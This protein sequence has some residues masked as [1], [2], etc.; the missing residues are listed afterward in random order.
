MCH[1]KKAL[2]GLIQAPRAWFLWLL[3][4]LF[5][6]VFLGSSI[7]TSLFTSHYGLIS[8]V[9]LINVDNLLIIRS[10]RGFIAT[11]TT[12]IK[13]EFSL[14]D[15]GALRYFLGIEVSQDTH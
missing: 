13:K 7:D 5:N 4:S 8:V 12:Q 14:K 11:L 10:C 2:Y 15:L 9:V 6:L 3:T 1:L